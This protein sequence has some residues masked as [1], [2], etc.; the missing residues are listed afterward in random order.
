MALWLVGIALAC[1][2]PNPAW[3]GAAG[4]SAT[5]GTA[6]A[7]ASSSP[8]AS[9]T[10]PTTNG[11]GCNGTAEICAEPTP[12]CGPA[13]CQAGTEGDACD[14]DDDCASGHACVGGTC[15]DGSTGDPCEN[16]EA[17]ASLLCG[18][19][20]QC[21]DGVEGDPCDGNGNCNPQHSC[22]EDVCVEK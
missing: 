17:C 21:Q 7:S 14:D 12:I 1:R 10:D 16:D 8:S 19:S 22:E 6:S 2:E 13:G 9:S 5:S 20:D 18:P 4:N 15:Y 3:R 11:S